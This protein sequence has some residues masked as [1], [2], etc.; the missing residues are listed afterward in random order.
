MIRTAYH[1]ACI[2]QDKRNLRKKIRKDESGWCYV[3]AAMGLNNDPADL[4]S[5]VNEVVGKGVLGQR[6]PPPG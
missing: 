6:L 2:G 1:I 4:A 5:V 3:W